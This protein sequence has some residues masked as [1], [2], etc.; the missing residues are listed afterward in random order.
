MHITRNIILFKRFHEIVIQVKCLRELPP[1]LVHE[2]NIHN[3]IDT[4]RNQL[5]C[6]KLTA[7]VLTRN[8]KGL[9]PK[10]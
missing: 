9:N 10:S 2:L 8:W 5:G 6:T 3:A 7:N 4:T 1:M